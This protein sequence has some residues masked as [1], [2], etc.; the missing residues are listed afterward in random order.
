MYLVV[1]MVPM[2]LKG[3]TLEF[4]LRYLRAQ[5]AAAT[6][7]LA[8]C[9]M[10]PAMLDVCPA[11]G[12]GQARPVHATKQT[13]PLRP[14]A[15]GTASMHA[16]KLMDHGPTALMPQSPCLHSTEEQL[17][18]ECSQD[19]LQRLATCSP[20]QQVMWMPMLCNWPGSGVL[21]GR[22]PY[23]LPAMPQ[24]PSD[25]PCSAATGIQSP[26]TANSRAPADLSVHAA[27]GL[28][29]PIALARQQTHQYSSNTGQ[30]QAAHAAMQE[31]RP[32][33]A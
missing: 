30:S 1:A 27:T 29:S 11:A 22:Y 5:H 24:V 14:A 26:T 4:P 15:K 3:P 31:P 18:I 9:I 19:D 16:Q 10:L 20:Q 23:A 2:S 28:H 12:G 25:V 7:I 17:D 21:Q 6:V 33:A 8:A 32:L 13:S